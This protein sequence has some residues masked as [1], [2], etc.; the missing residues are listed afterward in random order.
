MKVQRKLTIIIVMVLLTVVALGT[1][2]YAWFTLNNIAKVDQIEMGITSG[3][4]IDL[5]LD[6]K[7]WYSELSS[8]ELKSVT[9]GVNFDAVTSLD[10]KTFATMD[11]NVVKVTD[12]KYIEFTMYFRATNVLALENSEA[13][14]FLVGNNNNATYDNLGSTTAIVSEG[15]KWIPDTTF[16]YEQNKFLTPESSEMICYA[17][18]AI[19][20]SFT[21]NQATTIFDLSSDSGNES[22]KGYGYKYGAIAYYNSKKGTNLVAPGNQNVVFR[23]ELSIIDSQTVTA[24]NNN[25]LIT[26]LVFDTSDNN[27]YGETVIRIW[28]EGWDGDCFDS[29]LSDKVKA[30]LKFQFG[31]MSSN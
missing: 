25:S 5:S 9:E 18:D 7:N 15:C 19:R 22:Y 14:I 29:I 26:K 23:N 20:L 27:Y 30:Q 31:Q 12:K 8:E 6:K 28:I 1:S 10:G 11:N 24:N 4:G 21:H 13:G 17:K 3:V 16:E 2:T